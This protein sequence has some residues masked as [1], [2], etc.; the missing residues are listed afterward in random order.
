VLWH[1]IR[2]LNLSSITHMAASRVSL[3]RHSGGATFQ[4]RNLCPGV[5]AYGSIH[6]SDRRQKRATDN[7]STPPSL[8][9][10]GR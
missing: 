3:A 4:L 5:P 8:A 10:L 9:Y 1:D 2:T 6:G 7:A